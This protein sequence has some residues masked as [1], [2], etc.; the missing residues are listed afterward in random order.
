MSKIWWQNWAH[1][2]FHHRSHPHFHSMPFIERESK[3]FPG[4]GH[5]LAT[6]K[7]KTE[8]DNMKKKKKMV[9]YSEVH[10]TGQC[11]NYWSAE[12]MESLLKGWEKSLVQKR[13]QRAKWTWCKSGQM[14]TLS[15]HRLERNCLL[16]A[17][18]NGRKSEGRNP[19]YVPS[20]LCLKSHLL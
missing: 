20:E 9:P 6:E 4:L 18:S 12:W 14:L 11:P 17:A 19:Q 7:K 5:T 8:E 15:C 13:E 16:A 2:L 3:F 1:A 10:W